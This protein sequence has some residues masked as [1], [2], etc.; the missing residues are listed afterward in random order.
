MAQ[1]NTVKEKSKNPENKHERSSKTEQQ[2][3]FMQIRSAQT[4]C[5]SENS[6]VLFIF[7][8]ISFVRLVE[9][10]LPIFM[11]LN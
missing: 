8:C 6:I 7:V 2:N 4:K 3:R 1:S 10:P 11:P 9:N 5:A